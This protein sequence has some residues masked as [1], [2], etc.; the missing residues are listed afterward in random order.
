M[1]DHSRALG[2]LHDMGIKTEQEDGFGEDYE[3]NRKISEARDG[4]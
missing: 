1:I 3:H 4:R 2:R